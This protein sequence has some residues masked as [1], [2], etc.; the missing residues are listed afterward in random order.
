MTNE[1]RE[2]RAR[3]AAIFPR[4]RFEEDVDGTCVIRARAA[5]YKAD[6]LYEQAPGR[7]VGVFYIGRPARYLSRVGDLVEKHLG[8][9]GE[10][11]LHLTWSPKLARLLPWFSKRPAPSNAF[12]AEAAPANGK[13]GAIASTRNTRTDSCPEG[14]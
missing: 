2:Q 3:L 4:G 13:Q 6:H 14:G 1:C 7:L 12:V 11:I 8:G 10:G 5:R 9:D